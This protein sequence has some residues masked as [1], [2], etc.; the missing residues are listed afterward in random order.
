MPISSRGEIGVGGGSRGA[1]GI[2]G[3]GGR[4]VNPVYRETI[5]KQTRQAAE[6]KIT[7]KTKAIKEKI[8][9][10]DVKESSDIHIAKNNSGGSR[11]FSKGNYTPMG[12]KVPNKKR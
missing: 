8:K 11:P 9:S 4:N 2:T 1:G 3:S 6:A 7:Q 5:P 10:P 12:P